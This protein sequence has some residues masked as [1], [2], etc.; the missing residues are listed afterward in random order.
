MA[1]SPAQVVLAAPTFSGFWN[2]TGDNTQ[3]APF[4]N[5][6]PF[7]GL[8]GW[9]SK[10][11]WQIAKL[12][13]KQ[14]FREIKTLLFTLIGAAAGGTATKTY[15]RVSTPVGPNQTVPTTVSVVDMGGLVPIETVTVI[16]RVTT[17]ADITYLK[18]MFNNDMMNRGL[19][20]VV[21]LSGNG[22]SARQS[23][24]GV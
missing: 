16:N 24:L 12:A 2:L 22:S 13:D 4:N 23:A 18:S 20:F 19:T 11:E 3:Y 21:D 15:A 1:V 8:L 9:R 6:A 10:L 5:T 7:T 14:Q 17:A